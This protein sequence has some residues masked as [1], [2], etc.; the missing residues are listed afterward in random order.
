MADVDVG[1]CLDLLAGDARPRAILMYLEIIPDAAQVHVGGARRGAHQAGDRDQV[2]AGTRRRPR[3]R[4]PIPARWRAPTA[5]RRRA[6]PRRHP[7][8]RRARRAVRRRRNHWRASRRWNAAGVAIVTN[9]GGAGVLAVDQ[10]LDCGGD[11]AGLSPAKRSRR[12]T[13]RCPPTW[14][15]ANPVDIIGD[16]PPERYAAGR[17][18]GRRR[19]RRRRDPGDELPDRARLDPNGGSARCRGADGRRLDRRQA[20]CLPAGSASSDRSKRAVLQ[21]PALP[22]RHARPTRPRPWI[23]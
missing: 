8:G 15:H 19:P 13:R 4:R 17:R 5:C 21:E 23:S 16:A 10:L 22:L 7:A 3:R 6:A 18:G 1:D 12:S 11:L 9:G 20:A 14:S 2:R